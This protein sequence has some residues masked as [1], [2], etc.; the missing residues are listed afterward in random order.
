MNTREFRGTISKY[1]A[2][3]GGMTQEELRGRTKV[4]SNT[5]FGKYMRHPELMP[6]GVLEDIFQALGI[7]AEERRKC[8][9][10]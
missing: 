6:I 5:T 1:R 10:V 2:I 7:P 9:D 4:G 3:R 8:L